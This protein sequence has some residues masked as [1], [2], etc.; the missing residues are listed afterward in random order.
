MNAAS[1]A[2]FLN[3][4]VNPVV[5]GDSAFTMLVI[6]SLERGELPTFRLDAIMLP[7]VKIKSVSFI[8]TSN[9]VV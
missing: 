6:L 5:V 3:V 7:S 1:F 9:V 2:D 4:A 8:A